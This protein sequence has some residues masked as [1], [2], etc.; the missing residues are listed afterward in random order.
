MSQTCDSGNKITITKTALLRIGRLKIE[1]DLRLGYNHI[2]LDSVTEY[3]VLPVCL[4][5]IES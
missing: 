4:F 1:T 5:A 2:S 3:I